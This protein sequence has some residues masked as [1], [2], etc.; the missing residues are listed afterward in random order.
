M[1]NGLDD[2]T[3]DADKLDFIRSFLKNRHDS[4]GLIHHIPSAALTQTWCRV[5]R[6]LVKFANNSR[7]VSARNIQQKELRGLKRDLLRLWLGGKLS[8][9]SAVSMVNTS[10]KK[11]R[12]WERTCKLLR[13]EGS[14]TK[15]SQ[16]RGS[17]GRR[18]EQTQQCGSF[19][20]RFVVTPTQMINCATPQRSLRESIKLPSCHQSPHTL[21]LALKIMYHRAQQSRN[22]LKKALARSHAVWRRRKH[23]DDLANYRTVSPSHTHVSC[24]ENLAHRGRRQDANS[25]RETAPR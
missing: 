21:P 12:R 10:K 25:E 20:R 8:Q 6:C 23:L 17:M 3:D 19:Y 24:E 22:S 5:E 4:S 7:M 11:K 2:D 9:T 13:Q 1:G 14:P 16:Q 15:Q 18:T